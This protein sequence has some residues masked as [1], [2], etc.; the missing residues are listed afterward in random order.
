MK[1]YKIHS[2]ENK[3]YPNCDYG[4]N[5]SFTLKSNF[6]ASFELTLL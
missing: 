4:L 1:R 2:N 6:E 3:N 5:F